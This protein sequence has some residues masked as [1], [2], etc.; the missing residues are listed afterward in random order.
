MSHDDSQYRVPRCWP[1]GRGSG[2]LTTLGQEWTGAITDP[3]QQ[4]K[5]PLMVSPSMRFLYCCRAMAKLRK[6]KRF[7]G[8]LIVLLALPAA[9]LGIGCRG[10][11]DEGSKVTVP[12]IDPEARAKVDGMADYRLPEEN[13]YLAFGESYVVSASQDYANYIA[14]S[15]PSGFRF[16]ASVGDFWTSYCAISRRVMPRYKFKASAQLAI[17]GAGLGHT[18]EF[19]SKGLYE[20]TIGR[21]SEAFAPTPPSAEDLF[22]RRFA[23]EYGQWLNTVPWYDFAFGER[24]V[25]FWRT[26]SFSGPGE[27]RKGERRFALSA[28]LA[29]KAAYSWLIR[30]G[31]STVY[32]PS[33]ADIYALMRGLTP[34]TGAVD[35]RI[36]LVEVFRDGSQ[37]VKL[38]RYQPFTEVVQKLAVTNATFLEIAGNSNILLT[39][40]APDDWGP[41]AEAPPVMFE[42]Q[43][44]SGEGGKRVGISVPVTMLLDVVRK[45]E[46]SGA[47]LD[48]VYDY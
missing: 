42:A 23:Y 6:T 9:Y 36:E 48:H 14:R 39:V 47:R 15:Y 22:A 12:L 1:E 26:V 28:E 41:P 10:A 31:S 46:A 24:L 3:D 32:Q 11:S 25:T 7:L 30:G 38:P 4:L 44:L 19:V 27:F 33:E 16:F 34:N 5:P 37:L 18:A 13:T 17:Y 35:R 29:F 2:L 8:I 43:V 40:R 20:K 45:I 21:L